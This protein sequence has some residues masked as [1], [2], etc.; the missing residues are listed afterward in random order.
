MLL[1]LFRS[2]VNLICPVICTG[3]T[4]IGPNEETVLP[5]FLD[6]ACQ[7]ETG[8]PLLLEP[9][10][11]DKIEP[12]IIAHVLINYNSGVVPILLSNLTSKQMMILK[13]KVLADETP[14]TQCLN[15][16]SEPATHDICCSNSRQRLSTKT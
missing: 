8:Q 1:T 14:V 9:L 15:K 13:N 2:R 10:N 7:Y 11:T 3:A 16:E 4:I 12:F 6:A 5:C